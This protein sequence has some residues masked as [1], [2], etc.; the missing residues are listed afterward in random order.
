M[1]DLM[2]TEIF[3]M[4]I[5]VGMTGLFWIPYIL[6]RFA[7]RGI[8]GTL[9][10]PDASTPPQSEWAKRMID[11]HYNAVENLAIFVPLVLAVQITGVQSDTTAAA[12][13]IFFWA[14]LVHFLCYAFKIPVVRTLAFLVGWAAQVVLFF[15]LF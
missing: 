2:S 14:R 10:Y 11:A 1:E 15:A 6:D 12:A 5:T 3:W 4:V 7:T 8:M 9:G 13:M